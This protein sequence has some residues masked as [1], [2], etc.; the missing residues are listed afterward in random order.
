ML[1]GAALA[2]ITLIQHTAD[3]QNGQTFNVAANQ[4]LNRILDRLGGV[5]NVNS[6]GPLLTR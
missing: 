3:V 1:S 2:T 6:V 5:V 4:T